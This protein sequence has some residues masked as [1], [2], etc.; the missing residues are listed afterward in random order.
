M[1]PKPGLRFAAASRWPGDLAFSS[2][3]RGIRMDGSTA[4]LELGLGLSIELQLSFGVRVTLPGKYV[5]L[6]EEI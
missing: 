3:R 5:A 6:V 1:K 4:A 2:A